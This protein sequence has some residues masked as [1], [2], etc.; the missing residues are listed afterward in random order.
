MK[1]VTFRV[2]HSTLKL[3][4]VQGDAV[5]DVTDVV[6]G[7]KPA[8]TSRRQS[9]W[10]E[11]VAAT[12]MLKLL[13]CGPAA[14]ETLRMYVQSPASVLTSYK[15]DQVQLQAPIVRPGKIIGVGK[16]Y[17]DHAAEVGSATLAAPKLFTKFSSSVVGPGTQ[18]HAKPIIKKMDFEAELAVVIGRFASQVKAEDALDVVAGYTILNDLSAR[19]FQ[20]DVPQAQTSFAKSMDG[21][22]PMGPW[23]VTA[24]DIPDPQALDVS[25]ELN[26]QQM[27]HGHTSQMIF[28]VRTLIEYITQYVELEPGDVIATGTPAGVGAA[29][30]PPVW[31]KAG[32]QVRITVGSIGTLEH[33]IC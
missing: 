10:F 14:L 24:D 3:G 23:I 9:E 22:C 19:E 5:I 17:A 7:I 2:S 33:G 21:F 11:Q 6:G 18:V 15:L 30:N 13:G 1:L 28:S 25:L 4:V 12:S 16:N 26:G 8:S 32:D 31:L 20:R 29:R 27:Q